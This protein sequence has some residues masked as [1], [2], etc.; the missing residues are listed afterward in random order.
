MKINRIID[1]PREFIF[2]KITESCLYDIEKNTGKRPKIHQ[3]NGFKY[4]KNFGKNQSG[5]III[6]EFEAPSVYA[7]STQTDRGIFTT[8]W[9]LHRI[10]N[11][12]TEIKIYETQNANSLAQMINDKFVGLV[13]GHLK[14]RQVVAM[15][16]NMSKSYNGK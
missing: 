15:L 16:D 3:M 10:D 4:M 7:F 8:R 14:K 12:T 11:D 9:E 13:L 6:D 2:E 5:T 1:A